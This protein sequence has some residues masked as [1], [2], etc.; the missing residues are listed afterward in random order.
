VHQEQDHHEEKNSAYGD[1]GKEEQIPSVPLA[2]SPAAA[3]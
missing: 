3:A 1:A 2:A